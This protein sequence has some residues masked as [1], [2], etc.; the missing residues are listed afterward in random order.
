VTNDD[1]LMSLLGQ[2]GHTGVHEVVQFI[3]FSMP[4]MKCWQALYKFKL[5]QL[6]IP[7]QIHPDSHGLC[8]SLSLGEP[9]RLVHQDLEA[10]DD[11]N[12]TVPYSN[13]FGV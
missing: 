4:T 13:L 5:G 1:N 8:S 7:V 6:R 2:T 9:G 3:L 12:Q 10:Q 11:L